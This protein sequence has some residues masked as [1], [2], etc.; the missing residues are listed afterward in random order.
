MSINVK[1]RLAI[2]VS[3]VALSAA[4][5]AAFAYGSGQGYHPEGGTT[6]GTAWMNTEQ[7]RNEK[8]V[9]VDVVPDSRASSYQRQGDPADATAG[10]H[11]K[12]TMHERMHMKDSP[13]GSYPTVEQQSGLPK[14]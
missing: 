4:A 5:P 12:K 8:L 6:D 14:Y 9:P 13:R 3:V 7:G 1:N 2:V 11:S 10:P